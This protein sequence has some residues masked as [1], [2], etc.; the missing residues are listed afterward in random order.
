[1]VV[2]SFNSVSCEKNICWCW[3]LED[4]FGSAPPPPALDSGPSSHL[5]DGAFRVRVTF[6]SLS[7]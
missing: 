4:I 2:L 1:M 7:R 3:I 5:Q 6:R